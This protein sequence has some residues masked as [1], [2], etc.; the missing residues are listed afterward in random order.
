MTPTSENGRGDRSATEGA[1][2]GG[3]SA[4]PC[5][6]DIAC[7]RK[8][9][10][11]AMI[12]RRWRKMG[13]D[14]AQEDMARI[15]GVQL[16]DD[17]RNT[18]RLPVT[19][20]MAACGYYH[21][22]RLES[23]PE[24]YQFTDAA[25]TCLFVA[26]KSEDTLKK[27]RE[28]LCANHNLKNPDRIAT[29]D[30]K[31]FDAGSKMLISLERH[32]IESARFDF[33]VR[34]PMKMLAKIIKAVIGSG[35]D[36]SDFFV[37]AYKV[38]IDMYRTFAPLKHTTF[39]CAFTI[40]LLTAMITDKFRDVFIRLKPEHYYTNEE[41]VGEA[42]LDVLDLYTDHHR[43]TLLGQEID[44]PVF[45]QIKIEVN[46]HLEAARIPRYQRSFC[47]DCEREGFSPSPPPRSPARPAKGGLRCLFDAK[48]LKEEEAVYRRH[49][50]DEWEE[51]EE[52]VEEVIHEQR[53]QQQPP[54]YSR[55]DLGPE[56][57]APP[58]EPRGAL[59]GPRGR[60]RGRG[61]RGGHD[62]G[63]HPRGRP[64]RGRGVIH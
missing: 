8:Y 12:R 64:G 38:G 44:L 57:R 2:D 33:Q 7:S 23:P 20:Y 17:V 36:A 31:M 15:Q 14:L 29:P 3:T 26:C 37:E 11:E 19:T 5:I 42:M 51:W 45:I 50:E 13:R 22:F 9:F 47:R 46:Q 52:E 53:E 39:T 34:N 41:W 4:S 58:R 10:N 55:H 63:W 25:L 27:S 56:P 40:A 35:P 49:H 6:G 24:Q 18:L 59:R 62:P 30:D 60:G 21:Q 48:E 54:Q 43:S 28:I 1:E 16:I 32:A 61:G